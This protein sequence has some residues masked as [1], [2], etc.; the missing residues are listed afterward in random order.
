MSLRQAARAAAIETAHRHRASSR[1]L[2]DQI[3][4]VRRARRQ[5]AQG[6]T[7]GEEWMLLLLKRLNEELARLEETQALLVQAAEI[8]NH[9]APHR[10]A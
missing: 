8:A 7:D 5:I 6:I 4:R 3:D 9:A 10:A 2:Q 1:P